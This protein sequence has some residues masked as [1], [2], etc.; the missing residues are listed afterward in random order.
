MIVALD[1]NKKMLIQDDIKKLNFYVTLMDA[2]QKPGAVMF[3]FEGE[4]TELTVY[5]LSKI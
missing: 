3:L 5:S 2:K 1:M 4:Q